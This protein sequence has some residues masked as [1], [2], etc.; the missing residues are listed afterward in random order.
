MGI[1]FASI[2]FASIEFAVERVYSSHSKGAGPISTS[3]TE[4][5]RFGV[6]R[7][8]KAPAGIHQ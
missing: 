5:G 7:R 3:C 2:N 4:V 6:V 1:E 8:V